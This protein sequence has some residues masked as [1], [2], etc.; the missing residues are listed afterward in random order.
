VTHGLNVPMKFPRFFSLLDIFFFFE[1]VVDESAPSSKK[2]SL[3]LPAQCSPRDQADGG[4]LGMGPSKK[5]RKVR[6]YCS[7][8]ASSGHAVPRA[9]WVG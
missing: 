6:A 7:C 3:S 8:S 2:T 5:K 9:L 1:Q 4:A